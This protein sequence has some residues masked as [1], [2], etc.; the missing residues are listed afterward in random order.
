MAPLIFL[1]H[2]LDIFSTFEPVRRSEYM[3]IEVLFVGFYS[4][5][6]WWDYLQQCLS[7]KLQFI[8][9]SLLFPYFV[10]KVAWLQCLQHLLILK[11]TIA[12]AFF[13]LLLC[14]FFSVWL[15]SLLLIF[16]MSIYNSMPVFR[17][18]EGP[19][20]L[21]FENAIICQA[22]FL[23]TPLEVPQFSNGLAYLYRIPSYCTPNPEPVNSVWF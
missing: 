10:Q 15:P 16:Y 17:T 1:T 23:Q 7:V 20:G 14:V 19:G 9:L 5:S 22:M 18:I 21:Q 12:F 4:I 8:W 11:I 3:L 13:V 2:G 6:W